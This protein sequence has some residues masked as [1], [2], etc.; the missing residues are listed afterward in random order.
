M[1]RTSAR[2][3]PVLA[4]LALAAACSSDAASD[5]ANGAAARGGAPSNAGRSGASGSPPA[6]GGTSSRAGSSAAGAS[7]APDG[8]AGEGGSED[9]AELGGEAGADGSGGAAAGAGGDS[10]ESGSEGGRGGAGA[11]GEGDPNAPVFEVNVTRAS[12]IDPA[13]PGTVGIVTFSVDLPA[14]RAARIEFGLDQS[15]GMV[16]PVVWSKP[17]HRTLLLGMKPSR[18]Y[19]FRIV[20]EGESRSHASADY[21]LFTGPPTDAV[22]LER[23]SVLLPEAHERGFVVTSYWQ[24]PGA[25]VPFIL[26]ADGEIVWWYRGPP[27]A[28][29]RARISA[30]GENMWLAHA[31][32]TG[33]PLRRVSMDTLEV[34]TYPLAIG[35]HDITPVSGETMAFLEYGEDDCD[36]IYE[37][38]PSGLMHEIFESQGVVRSSGLPLSCHGNALRYSAAE[39]LYTFSE[40]RQD[41]LAIDRS[42]EVVWRLAERVE[43]GNAA[44]GNSQHGHHLLSDRLVLFANSADSNQSMVIEYALDGS[45][46]RRFQSAGYTTNFGDVQR[47]PGG[48]TLV[49]YSNLAFIQELDAQGAVALEISSAPSRFGY[50]TWR[51][52]LYGLSPDVND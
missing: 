11:G 46:L 10:G 21:T 2:F 16:A 35:S 24:G 3:G 25:G 4:F 52:T 6:G 13:A 41:V 12:D 33:A 5:G 38:D 15:Y 30:D 28:Y 36:S 20:V 44:W 18:T 47:L 29:A 14:V 22:E 17:E 26:D 49:T 40:W 43:G 50:A 37:I 1:T 34:E 23:F 39:D 32:N 8:G 27:E 51:P 48:N 45:E 9:G 31:A 19:H 42:G 7:G